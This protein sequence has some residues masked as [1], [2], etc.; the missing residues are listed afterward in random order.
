MILA[1]GL[2][3]R[4]RP[5]TEKVPKPM[6]QIASEPLIVYQVRWLKRSGYKS[7]V[8]NL[9]HLGDQI[10]NHLS[11]GRALGV[12]IKYS[13]EPTI[14]ETG[15]G[16]LNA[17]EL[18]GSDRFCVL[19]GDVWT[20]YR[21]QPSIPKGSLAHLV[22]I[23]RGERREADFNLIDDV[24]HRPQNRANANYIFSGISFL[25]P[26]LFTGQSNRPFSLTRDLLFDMIPSAQI[27]GE[28]FEGTWIDIGTHDQLK[29][30]RRIMF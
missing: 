17:L 18:L 28:I 11:T 14:L 6:L 2:G 15:G 26:E 29:R 23:P 24:I 22:L 1:A 16:I 19:N 30:V 9:H 27:T 8:I 10:R 21:F 25:H 20:N 4:L 12:E 3:K 13:H 7:I 5:L